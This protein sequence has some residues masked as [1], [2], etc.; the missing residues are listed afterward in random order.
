MGKRQRRLGMVGLALALSLVAAACGGQA[1][2]GGNQGQQGAT[3]QKGGVL[4]AAVDDFGFTGGFDPTGEYLGA[5]WGIYSAMV[6]PLMGYPFTA[7]EPGNKVVPDLADGMPEISPDGLTYTFKIKPNVKFQPPLDR[8]VT[9]KDVKYAFQR[10][11]ATPLAAQYGF[12]YTV[13]EG[14]DTKAKSAD[15][16]ISGITTPDD[17]TIVFKLTEPTGDF[18]NRLAQP[19]T[20]PIPPEAG[21]C[22]TK[23]G[24]YGRYVFASGPYMVKGSETTDV[25]SC[26]ALKPFS[27]F[28]PTKSLTLVRNPSYDQATDEIRKNYVDGFSLTINSNV[29]DIFNKVQS[30]EL[31]MNWTNEP[32]KPI[33]QQYLTDQTKKPNLHANSGDRT[34]YLS[35]NLTQAPFDDIHVR[36]AVNLVLDKAAML[37]AW[38]GSTAGEVGRHIMPPVMTGGQLG[39]EYD[40]YATPN[41]AGDEAKAKEEMKQSKYDTNKDG[42]CDAKECKGIVM[43][44]RNVSPWTET[45]PIVVSNLAKVGIELKPQ[46]QATSAAY[47]TLQT[48]K[49]NI[50]IALNAGWG[51]DYPDAFTFIGALFTSESILPEGNHNYAFIGLKQ[52][53][54]GPLGLK[55]SP[56]VSLPGSIDADVDACQKLTADDPNRVTC[57]N[58]LDRKLMEEFAPWAPYLWANEVTITGSTVTRFE[59]NQFAG[60]PS[61]TQS[62][63]NNTAT[64]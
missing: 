31:D 62:A 15:Q 53:Q 46:E 35:M 20:A 9:S 42:V 36:K 27:G 44:N 26:S 11:N 47:T 23:A 4:R 5:A 3:P 39:A 45:G 55:P 2:D 28:D 59:F 40:P 56:G 52:D 13:I 6:R 18:L 22:A 1:S 25:S 12:Y 49:N 61:I 17:Q 37:Q 60:V 14:L 19:A 24:D 29:D 50:K 51:K 8:A 33:L 54:I 43:I 21:K 41:D 57:W 64:P 48:T 10:I 7:G 63:V 58:D 38:G 30:G 32:P 34:W 16:D